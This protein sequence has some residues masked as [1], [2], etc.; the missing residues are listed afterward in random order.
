MKKTTLATLVGAA[1]FAAAGAANA[2]IVVGGENGY[3]FS[4]DGNIN[5]FFIASDQDSANGG[6]D[7]NNQGVA[8][9]LL[10]TFFGFN[11]KAPEING[12]TIGARVSISPSTNNGSYVS[13]SEAMEQ[14]EAFATVDGSFGQIM[15]G[16][17]LGL[18]AANNILLDQTLYG[19]GATSV[20]AAGDQNTGTTSLGRIGWGYDYANWRS[21]IRWTSVDMAGFKVALAVADGDDFLEVNNTTTGGYE[22]DARYE[23]SLSYASAFDGG[24][25]KLWLDGMTQK[26]SFNNVDSLKGNAYTVGGQLVLGGFEAVASY[27][28]GKA[29]GIGGLGLGAITANG[30]ERDGDGYYAQL[31]Y[32]FGG[33]TFVA[34]S[35]GESTLDRDGANTFAGTSNTNNTFADLDSNSMATI[36]IYHDVTANLKLVAEYS[37]METEYYIQ[38]DEDE[39]DVLAIGGFISW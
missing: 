11:V 1:A 3:E 4:V 22:K 10:P 21:Q 23:A 31:G 37:R 33:Q 36:G 14:R 16:K 34:A 17:G 6:Y 7:Q 29:Q 38:S 25:V 28:D 5:Q 19:V 13:S 8:N 39:V 18:Y 15:I 12:L 9:G 35:Y 24:S 26:V 32:R 2:T 20:I 27:Y 30:D